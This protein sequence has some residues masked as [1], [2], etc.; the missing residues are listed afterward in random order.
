MTRDI[1]LENNDVLLRPLVRQDIPFLKKLTKNADLWEYFTHNL[2]NDD[3]FEEWIKPHFK[4][5]RIQ[6]T[7][8]NKSNGEFVGSTALGNY[9]DRD[10]RIEIGWSWL[11]T[12]YH[13]SGINQT[14][15]KLILNYCFDNLSLE[16]V[17]FKTDILN[18]PA[19]H[20]LKKLGAIE[21]GVLRS[22][23]LLHH[24]RRRN[25]IYY[26]VLP[27][28]WIKIKRKDQIESTRT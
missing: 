13:G 2:S 14:M 15:K 10:K 23:T 11:G 16:R 7:V 8:I 12:P 26:S 3:Q 1:L 9:S 28:D 21:D 4:G 17:E 18:L 22:H 27:E 19:R 5:E 24:G 25:T 6:F 20:A